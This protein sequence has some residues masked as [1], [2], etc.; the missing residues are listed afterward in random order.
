[1]QHQPTHAPSP[2]SL[3]STNCTKTSHSMI[4]SAITTKTEVEATLGSYHE[5]DVRDVALA[6]V[7]IPKPPTNVT[8]S[9]LSH[10]PGMRYASLLP[11][12][13]PFVS[14]TYLFVIRWWRSLTR[15]SRARRTLLL[16]PF[17]LSLNTTRLITRNPET[18][19]G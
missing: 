6:H 18:N 7:L 16:S 2:S 1:M 19:W 17:P 9:L 13:I 8:L 4:N 15:T 12:L 5:V 10:S 11:F 14:C 3:C